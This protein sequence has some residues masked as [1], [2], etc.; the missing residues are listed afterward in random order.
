MEVPKSWS[1]D[2]SCIVTVVIA[3]APSVGRMI[4]II[5]QQKL[6]DI[7]KCH[8]AQSVSLTSVA[9]DGRNLS[10]VVTKLFPNGSV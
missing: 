3:L 6:D 2:Q 5:R 1:E 8:E 10:R 7:E 9:T 4:K